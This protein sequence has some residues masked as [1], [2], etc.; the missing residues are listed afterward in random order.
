MYKVQETKKKSVIS[1]LDI[2]DSIRYFLSKANYL[3]DI[4]F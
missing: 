4:E 3:N 1:Q 2:I